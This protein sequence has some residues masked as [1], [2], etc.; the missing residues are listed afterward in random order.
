MHKGTASRRDM[1]SVRI[2]GPSRSGKPWI[3][4]LKGRLRPSMMRP[5]VAAL[6][7]GA[8]LAASCAPSGLGNGAASLML[9][10]MDP[11]A[12]VTPTPFQ[13]ISE[14]GT[15]A[16]A[17]IEGPTVTPLPADT[18]T[19]PEPTATNVATDVPAPTATS[20]PITSSAPKDTSPPASG[21]P[22]TRY[23][24]Y[25]T[26]D[27]AGH[28]AAISEDIRYT[29]ATG[30]TLRTI[31]MA[32]EPNLWKD[33]FD[34]KLLD[35]DGSPVSNYTLE[36][37]RLTLT[38]PQPLPEGAATTISV[39]YQLAMPLQSGESPFGYRSDQLNLTDW[40]PFI[41]P[42]DGDW[43]LHAPWSFGE[44]L[45]YDSADFD[46]NV[47]MKDSG[48]TLAASAPAVVN[49]SSTAYHLEG[50]R[51]FVLSASDSYRVEESAVGSVKIEAYALPGHQDAN[52][53]VVWMATQSLGLYA[54]KFAPYPYPSLSIVEGDLA[55][56][57]E[58]DGLVF[59]GSKFYDDYGGTARSNLFTIGTH[60]IAHQWWFGLVGSDQEREP[61][62][63]EALAVYSERIFYEYDYPNYGDWWWD[64]RVNY[65]SPTGKVDAELNSFA[66]FQ[67]YVSAVYLNGA[68][69]LEELRGRVGDEAFFQFLQDYAS[70]YSRR[71]ATGEDFF[72]L[73]RQHTNKDLSD[74]MQTYLQGQY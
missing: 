62:L 39:G 12:T 61:W 1:A 52:K 45:V 25:V 9:V 70:T 2:L 57:Q 73:L 66:T 74:I 19:P 37:Q 63:D 18:A 10:T 38:L 29:N 68:K 28:S 55:D 32:V 33:C 56:G 50:A 24:L 54:A 30:Q 20:A 5:N 8:L 31:V 48:I 34:L 72:A 23:T 22:R 15:A 3:G 42:F 26:L 46:V 49:G 53:A 71:H 16:P 7:V 35:E 17:P 67:D 13:P 44:H 11:N 41:V 14:S 64:F 27:Y 60:E 6:I 21:N 59:L 40:Y 51:T 47:M 58:Y 36:G 65:F 69:M 4:P 43:V